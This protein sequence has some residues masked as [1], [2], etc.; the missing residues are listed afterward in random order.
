MGFG[1]A[2][3]GLD[4]RGERLRLPKSPAGDDRPQRDRVA[5][6]CLPVLPEVLNAGETIGL[7][8]KALLV[9]H[10]ALCSRCGKKRLIERIEGQEALLEG[11]SDEIVEQK[12]GGGLGTGHQHLRL[13]IEAFRT[14]TE[15][16][17]PTPAPQSTAAGEEVVGGRERGVGGVADLDH[18]EALGEGRLI[19]G[20]NIEKVGREREL[21]VRDGL[22]EQASEDENIVGA[23]GDGKREVHTFR[24]PRAVVPYAMA[25][26][27][28][29]TLLTVGK[30]RES[31]WRDALAEYTK[32]LTGQT[33]K[34]QLVEVEEDPSADS[35]REGE[36]LLSRIPERAWV[37]ACDGA[38]KTLSSEALAGRIEQVCTDGESHLIFVIG[39]ANGLSDTVRAR[40]NLLLSFGPMTFPH[41]LARVILAEQLYRA[42]KIN[43][44]EAYHR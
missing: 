31:F 27:P 30:L 24:I 16:E 33:S 29:V 26:R 34:L 10:D 12:V 18:V 3:A 28:Q 17:R 41:P 8:D 1:P 4:Q 22:G 7:V 21:W 42:F 35:E 11:L 39:G 15:Q 32:R 2:K 44:G 36:R 5:R 9:D 14:V 13:G 20:L 43:R 25:A 37:V 23:G 40:A 6:L 19:G 38:G